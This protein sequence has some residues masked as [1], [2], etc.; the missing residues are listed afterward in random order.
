MIS[1]RAELLQPLREIVSRARGVAFRSRHPLARGEDVRPFFIVGSGRSGSTL[2]RR[3]LLGNPEVHIPPEMYALSESIRI[4]RRR[5]APARPER[6]KATLAAFE[7]HPGFA[8][9]GVSLRPLADDLVAA[10]AAARSLALVLDALYRYHGRARGRVFVRWGDKTPLNAFH[11]HAITAVFPRAQIVHVLRDGVDAARSYVR[12]GLQ[13]DL[14]AAALRWRESVA[15]V[16][17]FMR[18]RPGA[19]REVR[20]EELVAQPRA[21][22]ADLCAFLDLAFDSSMLEAH[23]R[24]GALPDVARHPH[25]SAVFEPIGVGSIGRGRRGLAPVEAAR[26][27]R[28]IGAD[29]A[30]LGYAPA[31]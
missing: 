17:R 24:A 27:Q 11:L 10:P 13:P 26:L 20:Y 5:P 6:V 19:C 25:L 16:R 22:V 3:I 2:L 23:D 29:L 31:A 14:G 4:Y 21:V 8:E 30:R 1:K 28:L 9:L 7:S 12:A 18:E 15:A